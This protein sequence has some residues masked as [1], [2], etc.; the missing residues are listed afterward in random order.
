[1][2][3]ASDWELVR[4]F[5][6]AVPDLWERHPKPTKSSI[7]AIETRMGCRLPALL[8]AFARRSRSFSS[9]FL[10]LG[11]DFAQHTHLLAKNALVRTDPY[12][13]GAG[14]GGAL[15]A[16]LVLITENWME[17]HFWCLD[18]SD[19]AVEHPIVFWDR[20]GNR[21]PACA[22]FEAFIALQ[23]AHFESRGLH[24]PSREGA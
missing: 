4:R 15:P 19:P 17:D 5:D 9:V 22:D 18:T 23:L 12:W 2:T 11:P 13:T 6:A 8:L 20:F 10:G 16:H 7:A 24:R 21:L 3:D 1:M 14:K